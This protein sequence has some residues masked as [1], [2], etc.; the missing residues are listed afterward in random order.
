MGATYAGNAVLHLPKIAS[1][2]RP[3]LVRFSEPEASSIANKPFRFLILIS[4][5]N[6]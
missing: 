1:D 2:H 5:V 4:L 3:V 6:K